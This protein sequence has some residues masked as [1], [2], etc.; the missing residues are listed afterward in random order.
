MELESIK[1]R[2]LRLMCQLRGVRCTAAPAATIL[3][4]DGLVLVASW[5]SELGVVKLLLSHQANIVNA[6]RPM[7]GITCHIAS[8]QEYE[9]N[10]FRSNKL[11][12]VL[13]I[14]VI[15]VQLAEVICIP[16]LRFTIPHQFLVVVRQKLIQQS[17]VPGA[18]FNYEGYAVWVPFE[19]HQRIWG[20]VV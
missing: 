3:H 6:H 12:V 9:L 16:V 18:A 15:E 13:V 2:I 5:Y 1:Q 11:L 20:A 8:K 4:G 17:E 7:H 19:G 14:V 10:R